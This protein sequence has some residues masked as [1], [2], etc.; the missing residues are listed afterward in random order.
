MIELAAATQLLAQPLELGSQIGDQL[1]ELC[2][3]PAVV[4]AHPT[5]LGRT[6]LAGSPAWI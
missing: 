3:P 1:L 2:D 5:T 6:D 4:L